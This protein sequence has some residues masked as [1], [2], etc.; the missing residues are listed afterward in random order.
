M[1]KPTPSR[2]RGYPSA[3]RPRPRT[4][5]SLI[6]LMAATS[7]LTLLAIMAV[8]YAQTAKDREQEVQLV[9]SLTR[10]RKAI[11]LYAW[12]EDDGDNDGDGV[13][14]E[15]PAGDPDGDGIFDDDR[16]GRVD[17]DGPPNYPQTL[18]ALVDR[19]YLSAIPPDPFAA[20]K[21]SAPATQWT[22]L[23]ITRRATWVEAGPTV[24][25][26]DVVTAGIFDVRSRSS[27]RGLDGTTYSGW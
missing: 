10:I 13:S 9:D 25:T 1:V 17:E 19:G 22:T 2:S 8:P 6:E 24:Q 18:Q 5:Y 11:Q 20:N 16:D 4:G 3:V 7:I 27:A 26:T 21:A 23:A 14:G 12:N 15:D